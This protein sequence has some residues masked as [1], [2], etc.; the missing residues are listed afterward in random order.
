MQY[1][2][3]LL[4][5]KFIKLLN[6]FFKQMTIETFLRVPTKKS[7]DRSLIICF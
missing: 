1:V 5:S 7:K 3:V 6:L 2:K 4:N